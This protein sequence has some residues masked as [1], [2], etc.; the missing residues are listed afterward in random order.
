M[1]TSLLDRA[2][3]LAHEGH[4]GLTKTKDFIRSKV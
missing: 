2:V 1:P 4:Q 3:S